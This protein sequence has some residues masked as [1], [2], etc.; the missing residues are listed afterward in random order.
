MGKEEPLTLAPAD[1]RSGAARRFRD[2]IYM[3]C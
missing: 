3:H 2:A 1:M